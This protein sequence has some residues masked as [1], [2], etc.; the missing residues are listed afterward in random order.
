VSGRCLDDGWMLR[1]WVDDEGEWWSD[2]CFGDGSMMSVRRRFHSS[3]PSFHSSLPSFPSFPPP[4]PPF[5]ACLPSPPTLPRLPSQGWRR[6]GRGRGDEWK[7]RTGE[8][9]RNAGWGREG[10]G[11][12]GREGRRNGGRR[13]GGRLHDRS[14]TPH[15]RIHPNTFA[16][17][18]HV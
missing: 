8:G 1:L 10:D 18:N 14:A 5:L 17:S 11:G 15:R 6:E 9:G 13:N 7:A 3:F 2:G 12:R 16:P 4:F